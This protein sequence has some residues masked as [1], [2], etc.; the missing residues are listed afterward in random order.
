MKKK[1]KYTNEPMEKVRKVPGFLPS[2]KDLVLKDETV[3]ITISL[4][5][6]GV[7]FFG[8]EARSVRPNTRT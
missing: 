7:E 2:P 8:E 1:I 5:K 3:K 6:A 4:S